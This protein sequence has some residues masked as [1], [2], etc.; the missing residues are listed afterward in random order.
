MAL[1]RQ[2]EL[3]LSVE[4]YATARAHFEAILHRFQNDGEQ[5]LKT[6][7]KDATEG[8]AELKISKHPNSLSA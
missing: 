7:V 6:M 5:S 8:L 4:D 1:W 2:A 3:A